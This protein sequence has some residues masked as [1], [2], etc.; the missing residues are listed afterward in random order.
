MQVFVQVYLETCV[1]VEAIWVRWRGKACPSTVQRRN[2]RN[3]A[4]ELSVFTITKL[5]EL[6]FICYLLSLYLEI[7]PDRGAFSELVV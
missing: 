2:F 6:R 5:K 3:I 7:K 1:L 4:I